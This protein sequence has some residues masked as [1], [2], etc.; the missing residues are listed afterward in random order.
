MSADVP[1]GSGPD[2]VWTSA[3]PKAARSHQGRRAGIVSRLIASIVDLGVLAMSLAVAYVVASG[4]LFLVRPA[5]FT[6]PAPDRTVIVAVA[7]GLGL[8][9]LTISWAVN[10]GTVGDLLLGL[11]VVSRRGRRLGVGVALLR[12]ACCLIFPIGLFLAVGTSRRSLADLIVRS[13]VVYN[14]THSRAR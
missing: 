8:A 10:G 1:S 2:G 14:W 4:V 6:F 13:T 3:V 7:A 12:A 5:H 11:H 9:Y